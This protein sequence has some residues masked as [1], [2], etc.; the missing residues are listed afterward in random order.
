MCF[1]INSKSPHSAQCVKSRILNN[2]ID[3]ILSID[4]FEQQCVVIKVVLQSS[5]LEDHMKNIGIDLSLFKFSS[6]EHKCLNN[7]KYIYQHAGKCE[8]QQNLKD[9]L[10]A[11]MVSTLEGVTDNIPNLSMTSTPVKKT[12][13]RKSQFLFTNIFDVKKKTAKCRVGAA[14]SKRIAMKVGTSLWTKKKTKRV[15]KNQ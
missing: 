12:S 10:D 8:D 2:V 9:V 4:T 6:F 7:I 14:K 1:R 11:D 13:A 5:H 15:F 3:C